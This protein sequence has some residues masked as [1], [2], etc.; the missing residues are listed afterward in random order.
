MGIQDSGPFGG[1]RK[2][3]GPIIGRRVNG[4]NVITALH[5]PSNKPST[6]AQLDLQERFT[7]LTVFLNKIKPEVKPGFEKYARGRSALNAAFKYNYP[8]AFVESGGVLSLNYPSLVYSRGHVS[9]VTVLSLS[10]N[11]GVL[12]LSWAVQQESMYCRNTDLARVLVY[13]E[14]SE[15]ALCFPE[16]ANRGQ[17]G[18]SVPVPGS[19][20]GKLHCYLSFVSADG[21][22]VGDSRYLG[23]VMGS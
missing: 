6:S 16:V 3:T 17:L 22:L 9:I 10:L 20:T 23:E 4:M 21:K 11:S 18:C 12:A 13:D 19:F 2:K 7:L 8:H 1:F 14:E 5:H 15:G